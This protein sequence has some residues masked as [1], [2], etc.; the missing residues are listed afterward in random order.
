MWGTRSGAVNVDS[1]TLLFTIVDEICQ[2]IPEVITDLFDRRQL[3]ELRHHG[4]NE[5]E[6]HSHLRSEMSL[7]QLTQHSAL[8]S[9]ILL[10]S[11]AI[12]EIES[13]NTI[14]TTTAPK[15]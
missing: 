15:H 4:P 7:T 6:F 5:S 3:R 9:H 11:A 10:N 14:I 2:P 1:R 13:A 8:R 12:V